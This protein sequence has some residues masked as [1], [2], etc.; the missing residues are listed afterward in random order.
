MSYVQIE[1]QEEGRMRRER[2]LNTLKL[3]RKAASFMI[4][5]RLLRQFGAVPEDNTS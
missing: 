2:N 5:M 1:I 3:T 4:K